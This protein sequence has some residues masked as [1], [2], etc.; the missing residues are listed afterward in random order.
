MVYYVASIVSL[1]YLLMRNG[2]VI[3][4]T[5]RKLKIQQKSYL[6]HD[7]ELDAIVIALNILRYYFYDVYVDI[8]ID[9][10]SVTCVEHPQEVSSIN[11]LEEH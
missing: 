1:D 11:I 3:T 7:L 10:K 2:K 5:S 8:F 4:Y 6:T 9:H